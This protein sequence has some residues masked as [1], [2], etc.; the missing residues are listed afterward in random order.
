MKKSTK[1]RK[2]LRYGGLVL[3]VLVEREGKRENQEVKR[4][5][6]PL[7]ACSHENNQNQILR[8][9]NPKLQKSTSGQKI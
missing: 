2:T 6:P 3:C 9:E 1:M 7:P 4:A 5:C 8:H